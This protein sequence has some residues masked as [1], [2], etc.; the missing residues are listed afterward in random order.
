[1]C[2]AGSP[3]LLVGRAG[4]D[5]T[6]RLL[7]HTGKLAHNLPIRK[8][9]RLAGPQLGS[10]RRAQCRRRRRTRRRRP[11]RPLPDQSRTDT[12]AEHA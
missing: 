8:V 5:R 3:Q 4:R 9:T 6:R 2:S 1:V 7:F 12:A 10:R 11:V